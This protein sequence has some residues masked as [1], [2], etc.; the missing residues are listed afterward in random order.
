MV[1]WLLCLLNGWSYWGIIALFGNHKHIQFHL[2]HITLSVAVLWFYD[3][4]PLCPLNYHIYGST[5][6]NL[7]QVDEYITVMHLIDREAWQA[8]NH[9]VTKSRTWLSD[10]SSSMY[11]INYYAYINNYENYNNKMGN[12]YYII[13]NEKLIFLQNSKYVTKMIHKQKIHRP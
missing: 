13:F 8:T 9:G 6:D 7:R 3:P 2:W 1:Y 5:E 4:C 11:S 10:K 12:T